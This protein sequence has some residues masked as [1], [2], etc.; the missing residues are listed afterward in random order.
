MLQLDQR[1]SLGSRLAHGVNNR[2]SHA[3]R[4]GGRRVHVHVFNALALE[5]TN[6]KSVTV[7][8]IHNK[9]TVD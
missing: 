2:L 5:V 3:L 4:R 1:V 7:S 9:I 6:A 8:V